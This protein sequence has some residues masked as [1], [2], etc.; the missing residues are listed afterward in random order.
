MATVQKKLIY[1]M[2]IRFK[3]IIF[4]FTAFFLNG[5]FAQQ[6]FL[7][8]IDSFLHQK[9]TNY[10]EINNLFLKE[11]YDSTAM[12]RLL[13]KSKK[14][15]FIE[16]EIYA[17][18]MLGNIYR[19]HSK[20]D[21]AIEK[22][23]LALH[24][25]REIQNIP[26][27]VY[28]LN[29]L[30]VIYR[31][32]DA[33]KS[34][35]E[36]HNLALEKALSYPDTSRII[37]DNIAIANNSIGNIYLLLE[38]YDWALNHFN[39]SLDIEKHNNN[40]LG[41]AINYQNIGGVYE[42][43][44]DWKKAYKFYTLSLKYND[45]IHSRLGK[46]ICNTSLANLFYIQNKPQEALKLIYPNIEIAEQQGDKYY[47]ANVYYN[48]GKILSAIDSLEKAND[49]LIK[50]LQISKEKN[51][52]SI[53][54]DVYKELSLIKEKQKKY[55]EALG[56][57]KLY[58]EE[59]KKIFNEKNRQLITDL[60]LKQIQKENDFKLNELHQE[61][62]EISQELKKSRDSINFLIALFILLIILAYI[63][64]KQYKLNH[65]Q[66]M[67]NMQQSLLR[68]QMNP[69][70]IFN[71]LNSIKL[72]IIHNRSKD[73]ISFLSKFAK[74][75]RAI[76]HSTQEKETSLAEEIEMIKLYVSIENTRLNDSIDFSLEIDPQ[77]NLDQIIIPSFLTQPFIE[78]ALW[79]GLSQKKEGERKLDIRI[80]KKNNDTLVIQIEDNGIGRE[81]AQIIKKSRIFN[82]KS[83]G[84]NL[85]NERLKLFTK[86]EANK[87]TIRFIDK[88]E[89]NQPAGTI[90][91]IE[92]PLKHKTN[93]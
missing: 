23:E 6:D 81:K 61:K 19:I 21:E 90:V 50:A 17:L 77:L 20:Y 54:S 32:M 14:E 4:L 39:K 72:F 51:I 24:K 7:I 52:P 87:Y 93:E 34:A 84:V 83:V 40:L 57:S 73:A 5:L 67:V 30:G 62:N 55:N 41:L 75:I 25:S 9:P 74:L 65:H 1:L 10:R 43:K 59:Q 53:S 42:K 27:E 13:E 26:L 92:L 68:A 71:S 16:G 63:L 69:H 86:S 66:K 38:K 22:Y 12:K 64:Y 58:S 36:H 60:V 3:H 91:I 85:S 28:T 33:V 48:Y 46:I 78:N 47:I 2:Q 44:K 18:N 76:L 8:K 29:M 82:K 88:F 70:F 35:L 15:G 11:S 37:R 56:Y 49:Y 79:H 80:Y 31:R 45:S 89:N